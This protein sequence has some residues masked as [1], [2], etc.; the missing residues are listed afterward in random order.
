MAPFDRR[1]RPYSSLSVVL[2]LLLFFSSAASASSAVLGIDFGTEYI[3]AVLVKPGIPLDIVLTKDS[4]R[5]EASAIAFKPGTSSTGGGSFPERLYGGDA[6]ALA[7]RYPADVYPNLKPLLGVP[8][9]HPTAVATYLKRHPAVDLVAL[10]D[11]GT[12]AVKSGSFGSEEQQPFSVE[13]LL[14]MELKNVRDNAKAMAGEGTE[15]SSAVITIPPF[16]TADEKR[17]VQMAAELVGLKV[18]GLVSDGLAVGLNY[19]TTR[20]FPSV[21]EG[22][23]PEYHMVFDMG[24]GYTTATV[25]KFQGRAVKDVGRLNK[26][27]QEV[28]VLGTSWDRSLGGDSFNDVILDDMLQKFVATPSAKKLDASLET[29]KTQ[30]R[31]MARLLKDAEKVRQVLSANSDATVSFESLYNDIDFRYKLSRTEYEDMAKEYADRINKPIKEALESA[32]LEVVNL[33]SIILH[34]GA[35]RTPFVQKRLETLVGNPA[36]LRS[37][38][39]ADEAA[40]FGAAFKGAGLSPS[41]KVKEIRDID[42]AGYSVGI[43]YQIDGKDR[44]QKLFTST[45]QLGTVKHLPLKNLDDFDFTLFQTI[46]SLSDLSETDSPVLN[47]QT[48]NLTDSVKALLAKPGCDRENITASISVQLDP[49]TGFP[50]VTKGAV[51]CEIDPDRK[52]G[53]VVDDV[54]GF[55]GFGSKKE[56]Q[57]PLKEGEAP[58]SG[59][60]ES[61]TQTSSSAEP[62]KSKVSQVVEE[63]KPQPPKTKI[64]SINLRLVSTPRGSPQPSREQLKSMKKRSVPVPV[65]AFFQY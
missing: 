43:Q 46:S 62:V 59:S 22:G 4:K 37:N 45:A 1:R 35:V 38:V 64:E 14:A 54:K 11:R 39:N 41:F 9:D 51:S 49:A 34:G 2:C 27:I 28:V 29:V 65:I 61:T 7:A 50:A 60:E 40:V 48:K 42:T 10:P 5:K 23:K 18:M 55:F 20:T 33:D 52:N 19:A 63:A 36:K 6:L 8:F 16:Y 58:K 15:I 25:L 17:A 56:E 44:R 47:V 21:S 13:E 30:P 12:V 57:E 31:A 24:A 3:K 53:G 26:T 32:K